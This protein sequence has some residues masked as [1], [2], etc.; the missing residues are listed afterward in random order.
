VTVSISTGSVTIAVGHNITS[1]I[2]NFLPI[3]YS[4]NQ[5]TVTFP[6]V[7]YMPSATGNG[8]SNGTMATPT[9]L[10]TNSGT[11]APVNMLSIC[12]AVIALVLVL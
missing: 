7:T 1:V 10:Y 2:R 3:T 5:S 12:L 6:N 9:S 4:A 11:L 8:T